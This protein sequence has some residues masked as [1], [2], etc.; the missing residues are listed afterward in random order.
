MQVACPALFIAAMASGQGKTTVTAALARHHRNQGRRVR[1]FKTGPDY[2]DPQILEIASG[3]PVE[4]LDLWMAGEDYCREQLYQAARQADLILI[5]GAMGLLDGDPSSADLAAR[6]GVPV[7]VVIYARGMAQTTAAVAYGLAGYRRDFRFAG[8]IANGVGSDRH[9]TLIQDSLPSD[10][11][12]LATLPR[13]D[14]MTLPERH[15]GLVQPEEQQDLEPRLER[16]AALL[17]ETPLAALP[18]PVRFAAQPATIPAALLSG[19]RIAVAKDEAFSF[20]YAAN[21][22]LLEA[23]GATLVFFSPLR[24]SHLPDVDA[25]WLPGGYP[26]LHAARLAANQPMKT[27]L[28]AFYE[29]GKPMLAECGGM[30]YLQETLTDLEHHRHR[31]AG[32]IPGHGVMGSRRGCQGMQTAPLPEGDLRAHAHHHSRSHDTLPPLAHG[33]RQQHPAPGEAIVRSRGLTATYLH[34]FFPSNP[35]AIARLCSA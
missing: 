33:R 28:R 25:L 15:L 18:A 17:A 8:I 29:T 10:I 30:L 6:F 5:E 35:K 11:A 26:E 31:M 4:P 21:L 19:T 7:A 16:A 27:A 23:M 3:H 1:V 2:L 34:L 9:R 14:A 12:L 24:E 22:R 20:I 13:D 32:L